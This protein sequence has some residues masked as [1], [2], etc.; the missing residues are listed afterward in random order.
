MTLQQVISFIIQALRGGKNVIIGQTNK[1]VWLYN[2]NRKEYSRR[3]YEP[4]PA[5][6][7]TRKRLENHFIDQ[8]YT[9]HNG[10]HFISAKDGGYEIEANIYRIRQVSFP[11]NRENLNFCYEDNYKQVWIGTYKGL[12]CLDSNLVFKF[13]IIEGLGPRLSRCLYQWDEHEY[14]LGTQGL[15]LIR[16]SNGKAETS[17][18]HDYFNN[19]QINSIFRDQA[20][21]LWIGT[22]E[23]LYCYDRKTGHVEIFDL[24]D[25]IQGGRIFP[26]LSI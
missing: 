8:I 21:R 18:L 25:N 1:G 11:G 10:N 13:A 15:Y 7:A 2:P 19:I 22:D 12:Y 14:I 9:L 4:G 20:A 17:V 3:V 16:M 23:V 6:E 24:Y 26:K 5:G